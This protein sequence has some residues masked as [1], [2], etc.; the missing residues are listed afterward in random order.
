MED[1]SS[2][3]DVPTDTIVTPT[4]KGGIP[5]NTP[6]FSA[7]LVKKSEAFKRMDKLTINTII[8]VVR[9]DMIDN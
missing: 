7:D 8:Q 4:I 2:G 9:E 6:I 3:I 5:K 1:M